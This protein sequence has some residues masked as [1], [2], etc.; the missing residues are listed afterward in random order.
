VAVV[1][2]S[3]WLSDDA[4]ITLRTVRN[5]NEGYGLVWNTHER[6]QAY[7]HP[8]WMLLLS[9]TYF[10]TSETKNFQKFNEWLICFIITNSL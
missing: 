3:A 7:T 10:V 1:I 9:L 8:L 4:F 2:K 6:V 5:F